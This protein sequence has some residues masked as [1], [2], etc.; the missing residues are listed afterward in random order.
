M[1]C[2][3]TRMRADKSRAA[4]GDRD[5]KLAKEGKTIVWRTEI[6]WRVLGNVIKSLTSVDIRQGF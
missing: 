3:L 4:F 6:R 1:I 5:N 2:R